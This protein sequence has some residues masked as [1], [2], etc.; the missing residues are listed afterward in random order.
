M[1]EI[2]YECNDCGEM[3]PCV[4]YGNGHDLVPKLCPFGFNGDDGPKWEPCL[5]DPPADISEGS[6]ISFTEGSEV[7]KEGL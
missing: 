1:A 3:N 7:D 4:A 5:I 2:K 6:G